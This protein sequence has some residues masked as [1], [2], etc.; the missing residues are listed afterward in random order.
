M[1]DEEIGAASHP[2]LRPQ[3]EKGMGRGDSS[4]GRLG[5]VGVADGLEPAGGLALLVR[6]RHGEVGHHVVG[7]RAVPVLGAG[8]DHDRIARQQHLHPLAVHLIAAD[9]GEH[10]EHLAYGVRVPV[11]AATRREGDARGAQ[12]RWRLRREHLLVQDGAAEVPGGRFVGGPGCR[13]HDPV[14]HGC[15]PSDCKLSRLSAMLPM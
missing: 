1:L 5:V 15:P 4:R 14:A 12:A 8:R 10:V 11:G 2:N 3:A 9:A 13:P 6:L 7:C